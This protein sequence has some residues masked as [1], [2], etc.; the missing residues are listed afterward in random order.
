[1]AVSE[2]NQ[3]VTR[4]L[5]RFVQA[6]VVIFC[7]SAL[8]FF[9]THLLGDPAALIAPVGATR[10]QVA[11]ISHQMGFDRPITTQFLDFLSAAVRGD[12]GVSLRHEQ[13]ALG[14]ILTTL[15]NTLQLAVIAQVL[16]LV[17]AVPA[18]VFAATRRN[19]I[20]DGLTM[21]GAVLGQS[22]P[23]FWLGL[24]LIIVVGVN[25]RL[26]PI[27]GM[28]DWR[29]LILPAV[30]LSTYPMARTARL[31]RSGML[32]VLGQEY[33]QTARAKG[34]TERLVLWKHALKNAL[35]PVVTIVSLD[36]G[37]LLGGAVVTESIFA[38]PGLGRLIINAIN[39][40]DF[41]LIQASVIVVAVVFVTI[42][43]LVDATY[44][45][46]DPRIRRA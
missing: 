12:L 8:V 43:L 3:M 32:E 15:P 5:A 16:A 46:I 1:M 37:T 35:I 40:R 30:T 10:E 26:L 33:I 39:T 6:V 45:L 7:V 21:A 25:L 17:V 20:V 31:V 23:S 11:E 38:W 27:S 2:E 9:A 44:T 41:P 19:T 28:G 42:N 24:M 29:H 4:I 36:F 34:L 22:V 18:G 13:P 14:L